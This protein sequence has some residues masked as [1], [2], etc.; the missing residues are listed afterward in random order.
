MTY[1]VCENKSLVD[2]SGNSNK[3]QS[4]TENTN[5]FQTNFH[6][7]RSSFLYIVLPFTVNCVD[8]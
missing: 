7:T 5:Y 8:G 6:K 3:K 4:T 2:I 1:A